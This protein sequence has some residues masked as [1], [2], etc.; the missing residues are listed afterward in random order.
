MIRIDRHKLLRFL[1]KAI[2]LL[3]LFAAGDNLYGEEMEVPVGQQ[4]SIFMKI[5]ECNRGFETHDDSV[6]TFGIIYQSGNKKSLNTHDELMGI[7]SKSPR[8]IINK[9]PVKFIAIDLSHNTDL[10]GALTALKID[11]VYVTPLRACNI[12]DLSAIFAVHKILTF[13]GVPSYL[14]SGLAVSIA[15]HGGKPQIVINLPASKAE[16]VN[17]SSQILKLARIME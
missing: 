17:F 5:L 8:I 11:I 15:N 7:I 13:T 9:I 6:F 4:F 14:E 10:A 2:L 1:S 3:L 16:G 12:E